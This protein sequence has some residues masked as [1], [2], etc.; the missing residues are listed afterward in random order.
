MIDSTNLEKAI[1]YRDRL[2]ELLIFRKGVTEW[3][4]DVHCQFGS[5][6]VRISMGSSP[7]AFL[8]LLDFEEKMFRSTL[9]LWGVRFDG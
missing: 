8:A 2:K 6:A 5:Y 1:E 3:R 7:E 4:G 9:E